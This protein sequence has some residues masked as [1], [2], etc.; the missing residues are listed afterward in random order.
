V[1]DLPGILIADD[2]IRSLE[3]LRR[4]LSEDFDVPCMVCTAH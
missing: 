4:I 2:E 1:S 3:A